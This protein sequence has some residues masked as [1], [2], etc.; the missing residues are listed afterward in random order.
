MCFCDKKR[1]PAAYSVYSSNA[2]TFSSELQKA[3]ARTLGIVNRKSLVGQMILRRFEISPLVRDSSAYTTQH[4]HNGN[5]FYINARKTV[6]NI[7]QCL[8]TPTATY[9]QPRHQTNMTESLNQ[10][11]RTSPVLCNPL[12]P[13]RHELSVQAPSFALLSLIF[14]EPIL[15]LSKLSV[16]QKPWPWLHQTLFSVRP[17]WRDSHFKRI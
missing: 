11:G 6:G 7:L 2:S 16:R 17:G 8:N 14:L 15:R 1:K 12:I 13:P 3:S 5:V 4:M 10:P 9:F